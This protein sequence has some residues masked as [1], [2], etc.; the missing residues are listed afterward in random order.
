MTEL[1][2]VSTKPYADPFNDVQLDVIFLDPD[3]QEKQVPAFW[4]GGQSWGVRYASSLIGEH[5]YRTVCSDEGN[6]DLHDRRGEI[7]AASTKPASPGSPIMHASI[8]PTSTSLISA[9]TGL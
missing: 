3:G 6:A 7:E 4:A 8:R 1:S 2:Y 5:H 9:S